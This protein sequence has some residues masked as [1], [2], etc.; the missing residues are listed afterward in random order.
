MQRFR[1]F[2]S[3]TCIN[4]EKAAHLRGFSFFMNKF[5]KN[6]NSFMTFVSQFTIFVNWF[7]VFVNWL[8]LLVKQFIFLMHL[9]VIIANRFTLLV[10]RFT[11]YVNSPIKAL[12]GLTR[13]EAVELG[14]RARPGRSHRC[15][16]GWRRAFGHPHPTVDSPA[17]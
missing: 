14:K 13:V 10:E 6:V 15:P 4:I 9:L 11:F 3:G 1:D 5:M 16:R 17:L 7:M 12:N 8:T 2:I